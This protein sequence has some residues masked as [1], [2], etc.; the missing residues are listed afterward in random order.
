M[1][2]KAVDAF[3]KSEERVNAAFALPEM[4]LDEMGRLRSDFVPMKDIDYFVHVDLAQKHD[5]AA[6]ALSHVGGWGY[7]DGN[8]KI[9]NLR[10]VQPKI[11]VDLVKYW[12]PRSDQPIDLKD[13]YDFILDIH[14]A[15]FKLK[16][17]TFDRWNSTQT[18]EDLRAYGIKA[19]V[20]SV[21][22][23]HYTDFLIAVN[24]G[25]VDGPDVELLKTEMLEL[26]IMKN[27]K[28]D[29]PRKG[30]KDLADAVAG[31][32]YNAAKYSVR[33]DFTEIDVF[34][35]K[36]TKADEIERAKNTA[37]IPRRAPEGSAIPLELEEFLRS[38]RTI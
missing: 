31:A 4:A 23:P 10:G 28:V 33:K 17:V 19:E 37:V 1:P 36:A 18:I 8:D 15:G 38:M 9:R 25:R 30:S 35:M 20:L 12:T 26:R 7:I 5:H 32:I 27:N 24:E 29:H 21:A 3:F 6:V 16:L 11:V 2:P 34:T 14:R 13:I 22:L